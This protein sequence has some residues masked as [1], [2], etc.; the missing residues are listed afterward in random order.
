ML[1]PRPRARPHHTYIITLHLTY[2]FPSAGHRPPGSDQGSA[3][4]HGGLIWPGAAHSSPWTSLEVG[5]AGEVSQ[6]LGIL[7]GGGQFPP[8]SQGLQTAPHSWF[9][10]E[11]GRWGNATSCPPSP[12]HYKLPH[13][14]Q[15]LA[16]RFCRHET[17]A[18]A[19]ALAVLGCSGPLEERAAAL[20]GL[21]ELA[22]ALRPG[23][24]GNLPGLAA[25]MGA[26]LMPQVRGE[27]GVEEAG[28]RVTGKTGEEACAGLF[29]QVSRLEHTWRQLRRSHTEAALAFEQELKPLMRALDEGAGELRSG[30]WHPPGAQT[31]FNR[32]LN[33]VLCPVP[34]SVLG[35]ALHTRLVPRS[36]PLTSLDPSPFP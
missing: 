17:L 29:S 27:Q 11:E 10:R 14:P 13:C 5:T 26:L 30:A 15:T 16:L 22:L 34:T 28:V 25:V 24:A 32:N 18:L 33:L 20:R 35:P 2:P 3:G 4:Q 23:A 6:P 9:P 31:K 8:T 12:L 19:G 7:A 21:V 36:R 1:L